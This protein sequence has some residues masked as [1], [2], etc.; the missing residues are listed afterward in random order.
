[1]PPRPTPALD[2][3]SIEQFKK[4]FGK[5]KV[6]G[7]DKV[8]AQM[9]GGSLM[10]CHKKLYDST[11]IWIEELTPVFQMMDALIVTRDLRPRSR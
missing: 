8:L 10:E 1:M 6:E 5:V 11:G 7:L 3:L 4:H 9:N 2:K